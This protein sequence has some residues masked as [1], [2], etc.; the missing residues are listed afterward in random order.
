VIDIIT[1]VKSLQVNCPFSFSR[2]EW[3]LNFLNRISEKAQISNFIK[4]RPLGAELF[5]SDEQADMTKLTVAFHSFVNERKNYH[6]IFRTNKIRNNINSMLVSVLSSGWKKQSE[7]WNHYPRPQLSLTPNFVLAIPLLLEEKHL[8]HRR[9][10]FVSFW[11][12]IAKRVLWI[13]ASGHI[14]QHSPTSFGTHTHTHTSAQ[15]PFN[16]DVLANMKKG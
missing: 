1:N 13:T 10:R 5:H 9:L 16:H 11:Y 3:N 6:S 15:I 2:F 12:D 4:I 8:A 7:I 14:V